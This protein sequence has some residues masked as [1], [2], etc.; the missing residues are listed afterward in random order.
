VAEAS[1]FVGDDELV[2][3]WSRPIRATITRGIAARIHQ[4]HDDDD[5]DD[6]D[7]EKDGGAASPLSSAFGFGVIVL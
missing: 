5:D 2:R 7:E 1:R 6:D 3:I 4:Q